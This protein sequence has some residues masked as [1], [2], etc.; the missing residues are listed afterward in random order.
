MIIEV[1]L[2]CFSNSRG[3]ES[4]LFIYKVQVVIYVV[5][6]IY[7]LVIKSSNL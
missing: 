3:F 1:G 5:F 6:E 4:L 2:N 7:G